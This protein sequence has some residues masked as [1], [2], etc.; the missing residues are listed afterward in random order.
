MPRIDKDGKRRGQ[1]YLCSNPNCRRVF[2]RPKIIRYYVCPTCQTLVDMTKTEDL[3]EI[4]VAP[5]TPKL[6][7]RRRP[8]IIEPERTQGLGTIDMQAR[9]DQPP[10]E[11]QC[12]PAEKETEASEKAIVLGQVQ[13]SQQKTTEL[14]P[15][16]QVAAVETKTVSPSSSSCQY[17]FGYLSQRKKAEAIPD[18]C[19]ECPKSLN[20]MLSEYYKSGE[21]VKEIKKWYKF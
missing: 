2:P 8:K 1:K 6:V 5:A 4:Q 16:Q 21:S 7:T 19:I 15:T 20:C 13:P 12:T 3:A 18:T 14:A 10:L 17:G 9:S 11:E